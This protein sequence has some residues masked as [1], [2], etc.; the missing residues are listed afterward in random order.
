MGHR[1]IQ[2]VLRIG[3]ETRPEDDAG[4]VIGSFSANSASSAFN[5]LG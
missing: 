5:R 1:W 2:G 4:L 3:A